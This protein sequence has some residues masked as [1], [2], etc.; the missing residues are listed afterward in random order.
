MS[1]RQLVA[2]HNGRRHSASGLALGFEFA[3]DR[4]ALRTKAV[5]ARIEQVWEVVG[6][7]DRLASLARDRLAALEETSRHGKG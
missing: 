5:D 7:L 4:A 1:W 6:D 2:S 3:L